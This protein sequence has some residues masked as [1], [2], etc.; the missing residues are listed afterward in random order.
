V[1]RGERKRRRR[2]KWSP[3]TAFARVSRFANKSSRLSRRGCRIRPP[4]KWRTYRCERLG[5]ASVV[6][7]SLQRAGLLL[8]EVLLGANL[9]RAREAGGQ[10][11]VGEAPRDEKPVERVKPFL[12]SS[13]GI[14]PRPRWRS[15]SSCQPCTCPR[16][17][18]RPPS[19]GE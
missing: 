15:R 12:A 9:R 10:R 8:G 4:R 7:I 16:S 19:P 3:K 18:P 1:E 11:K 14:S 17:A 2:M 5:H 6:L 13:R